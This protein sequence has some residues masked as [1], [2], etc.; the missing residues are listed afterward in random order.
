MAKT[1]TLFMTKA[2]EKPLI[3]FGAAHIYIAHI[4]EYPPQGNGRESSTY[5]LILGLTFKLL[6]II[7]GLFWHIETNWISLVRMY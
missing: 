4:K 5:I 7:Q 6:Q 1:N 3:P 2:A